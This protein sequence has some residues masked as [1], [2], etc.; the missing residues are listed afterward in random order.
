MAQLL[1]EKAQLQAR[2]DDIY[3]VI[4][5][6]Q[7][8]L[9]AKRKEMKE[10]SGS[11]E[12]VGKRLAEAKQTQSGLSSEF[13]VL[14][15]ME[16]NRQGLSESV[17]QI[18]RERTNVDSGRYDYIDGI[19]A[20]IISAEADYATAVEAALEGKTDALVINSARDFLDDGRIRD[21][22]DSRVNLI[23]ADRIEPFVDT[24]DL[25]Q[26]PAVLGRVVEFV[27]YDGKKKNK[28]VIGEGVFV[29]CDTVLVAPVT[30]GKGAVTGAGSVVTRN[31]PA[32]TVV[33][34]VPAKKLKKKGK[35]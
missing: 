17:K 13:K 19:V 18:L 16:A 14:S 24:Q 1:T 15:D 9:D 4:A 26:Y 22:L 3:K 5:E 12:D 8:S 2:L 20:D 32:Q 28:T 21:K 29:G 7:E 27:N 33:V 25:S 30:V 6:L 34:G 35:R 11:Q 23:C 31:V 10:I